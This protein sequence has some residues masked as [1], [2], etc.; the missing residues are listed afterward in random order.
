MQFGKVDV[1][2]I[3]AGISCPLQPWLESTPEDFDRMHAVNAKGPFLTAKH[4]VKAMLD[5]PG[6]GK[7][8]S[9]VFVSSVA[10]L[11]GEP[12]MA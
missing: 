12:G 8:G 9:L 4:A 1:A 6:R 10:S 2:V 5:S 3:N 11:Y 7:G